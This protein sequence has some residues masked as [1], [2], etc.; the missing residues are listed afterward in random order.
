M[1]SHL[2][3]PEKC[4]GCMACYNSCSKHAI[5]MKEGFLG[6]LLPEISPVLCVDC[7]ACDRVCPVLKPVVVK[8]PDKCFAA[9]STDVGEYTSS[10]SGGLA[11]VMS[12]RIIDNGGVVYGCAAKG[13]NVQHIRCTNLEEIKQLKGSKY[14]QS[15]IGNT[16]QQVASDL[17]ANKKVLF[18][19]TPCQVAGLK[20]Y[21]RKGYDHLIT[22][23]LICHGVPSL[24]SLRKSLQHCFPEADLDQVYFLSFRNHLKGEYC[25]EVAA[26]NL[27][28]KDVR[29]EG[30]VDYTNSYYPTFFYGNSCRNS[31]YH[32]AYASSK[33]CSDI[34]IGDFWGLRDLE[35]LSKASHGISAVLVNTQKGASFY[36]EITPFLHSYER[37]VEEAVS[38]NAQLQQPTQMT[39]R[40]KIFRK[41]NKITSFEVAYRTVYCKEIAIASL[42]R[43]I[44]KMIC[45]K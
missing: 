15:T 38:G 3:A 13:L 26:S 41:L 28:K 23:D 39:F 21:L 8:E 14:V 6:E 11:A 43:R 33:R 20:S 29:Y 31:C 16:Y 5:S 42:K 1:K 35:I 9:W 25:L 44:K 19:G 30:G 2:C 24:Q 18:I 17:K 32:C 27:K 37:T 4:T 10:T 22:V 36:H 40:T 7:G 12:R 45:K 34:T